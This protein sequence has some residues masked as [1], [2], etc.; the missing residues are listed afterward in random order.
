M[1][2]VIILEAVDQNRP[3]IQAL[4]IS[5]TR[6]IALQSKIVIDCLG[7][8]LPNLKCQLFVGGMLA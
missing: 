7:Q 3:V 1:F 5:P 4:V 6:E 8:H 2:A